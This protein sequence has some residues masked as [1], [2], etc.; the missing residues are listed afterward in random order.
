MSLKSSTEKVGEVVTQ[1]IGFKD[2]S[3]KTFRNIKTSS[4]TQSEFTRMETTDGYWIYVNPDNVN[5]FE[6]HNNKK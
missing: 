5:W 4:I 2:G 1:I 6:V 3:K